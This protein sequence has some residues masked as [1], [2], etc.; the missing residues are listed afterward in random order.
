M[1][2]GRHS[3]EHF[4]RMISSSKTEATT[5]NPERI[6]GGDEQNK[7]KSEET[8]ERTVNSKEGENDVTIKNLKNLKNRTERLL[9]MQ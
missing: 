6:A 2:N 4:S 5:A 8:N 3:N 9:L 1:K 7:A